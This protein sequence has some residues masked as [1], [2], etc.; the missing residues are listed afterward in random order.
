VQTKPSVPVGWHACWYSFSCLWSYRIMTKIC[1][2]YSKR[3]PAGMLVTRNPPNLY[4][5][6][7]GCT[8][9]I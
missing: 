3:I 2:F 8:A 1:L 5:A 9:D 6:L 4:P 7:G